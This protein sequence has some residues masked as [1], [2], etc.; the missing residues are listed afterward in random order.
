MGTTVSKTPIDDEKMSKIELF[1]ALQKMKTILSQKEYSA[2]YRVL[3]H[4]TMGPEDELTT[5]ETK[6]DY[7]VPSWNTVL[8]LW[9]DSDSRLRSF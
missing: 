9:K 6:Q 8:S 1:N 4:H 5:I 3:V 2:I 7:V